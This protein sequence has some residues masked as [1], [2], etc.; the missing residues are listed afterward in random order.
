MIDRD[1]VERLCRGQLDAV[2]TAFRQGY[3]ITAPDE[4]ARRQPPDTG[5]VVDIEDAGKDR[6]DQ[7][8]C[9]STSGTWIT[10]R[11]RP[12]WRIACAKLS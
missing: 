9:S 10:D 5:V 3:A 11:N 8:Q 4:R 12:S 7:D 2:V 6:L 1:Q